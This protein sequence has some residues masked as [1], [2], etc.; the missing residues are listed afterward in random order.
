MN[1]KNAKTLKIL[2]LI[3]STGLYGAERVLLELSKEL[4]RQGHEPIVGV[5][6]NL[7]NPHTEVADEAANIG[8]KTAIFPCKRR[9][10]LSLV[11]VIRKYV[12]ENNIDIIHSH[13]YKSNF[14]ALLAGRGIPKVTT[15]HNWLTHHW[16]L[17]IYCLLDAFWIRFF[18]RIVAVSDKI[19]ADMIKYGVPEKKIEV[20]YNGVDIDRFKNI[21][22]ENKLALKISL[23]IKEGEKVVGTIGALKV[24][25]GHTYLLKAAQKVLKDYKAVKFL[26][27]GDGYLRED[28]ENE[29]KYLGI[30]NNVIFTGYRN[31]VPE[32]LSIMDIFVLPSLK[33]GLPMVLLEAMIARCK[34]IATK[35]GAIETVINKDENAI[36]IQKQDIEAF[37]KALISFISNS[38]QSL[39]LSSSDNG[40]SALKFSSKT[41]AKNC[42]QVYKACL[43]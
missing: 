33:E 37:V 31:D 40:S 1:A 16:K 8:L 34:I 39:R 6:K 11:K 19:K 7:Y 28:L 27:V 41:M 13:G 9:F 22:E 14:Y 29:V 24:E 3:S 36:L 12:K 26:I 20:I 10:D 15:N 25:K 30:E 17:K 18:D 38:H 43:K 42:C 32:L 5:I 4:K 35:V 2:H 23:G 21:P